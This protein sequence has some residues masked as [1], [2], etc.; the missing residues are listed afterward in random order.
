MKSKVYLETTIPSYLTA[1]PSRD[2]ILT[3]H[4]RITRDWWDRRDRFYLFV[5]DLVIREA[6]GGGQEAAARR[7]QSIEAAGVLPL[8][9]EATPLARALLDEGPIPEKAAID[10]LYISI[11]VING[12]DYLLTWNCAHIA[13]AAMRTRIEAVCRSRGYEPPVICTPEELM[14]GEENV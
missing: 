6:G 9:E 5:S 7:L 12:M 8:S 11:A 3:A 10:A 1:L 14:V 2:L 4:Q 13:K